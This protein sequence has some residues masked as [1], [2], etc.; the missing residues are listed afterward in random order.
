MGNWLSTLPHKHNQKVL[1]FMEQKPHFPTMPIGP[2]Q[3]IM[4]D[5]PV[6]WKAD[7]HYKLRL[8]DMESHEIKPTSLVTLIKDTCNTPRTANRTALKV[9]RN[10]EWIGWTYAQYYCDIQCLSRAFVKLGLK[11]RHAVA[12]SGFNSPEW[13]ISEMACI[14]SGGMVSISVLLQ[15]MIYHNFLFW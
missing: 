11:P 4:T 1:P 10:G 14:F 3:I 15:V 6:T 5:N 9:K 7:G 8:P 12:I 13:F 2:D